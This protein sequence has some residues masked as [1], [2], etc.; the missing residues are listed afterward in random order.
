MLRHQ[1]LGVE[2]HNRTKKIKVSEGSFF[3]SVRCDTAGEHIDFY[4]VV[5]NEVFVL[6]VFYTK[7]KKLTQLNDWQNIINLTI[8]T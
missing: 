3:H 6:F 2:L 4:A 8:I 5:T 7:E 1:P